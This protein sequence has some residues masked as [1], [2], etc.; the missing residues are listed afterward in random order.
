MIHV[1]LDKLTEWNK[2]E[3]IMLI[4]AKSI[5]YLVSKTQLFYLSPLLSF[6]STNNTTYLLQEHTMFIPKKKFS[7]SLFLFLSTIILYS[8]D[9]QH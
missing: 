1:K 8:L 9:E 2:S 5:L 3:K 6:L 4:G 7:F